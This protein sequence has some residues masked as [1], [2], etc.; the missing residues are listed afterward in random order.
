M[1]EVNL[2]KITELRHT[3]HKHAE[4]PCKEFQT[5]Q[6]LIDFL[7]KN[8][9]LDIVDKGAWFY[10]IHKEN[11]KNRTI[12][13]RAD[14]DAVLA[15][16]GKPKHMCGH[17]GHSAGLCGLALEI[18]GKEFG[19]NIILLF[20]HAEEIGYGA[21]ECSKVI[22]EC[23]IDEIYGL[24]NIPGYEKGEI[25]VRKGT[26]SCASKG[27][28]I[29]FKGTPAHAAYPEDGKNP[30]FAV[31]QLLNEIKA[32]ANPD[33]YKELVLCTVVG[34]K[35]G[36]KAFGVSASYGEI[37]LTIRGAIEEELYMLQREIEEKVIELAKAEE[38]NF[39]I[40]Y[41][42]EFPATVNH[43]E[44]VEHIIAAGKR[45]GRHIHILKEPMRWSED[46]GHYLKMVKGAFLGVGAGKN[47]P[48]LH[49]AEYEYPDEVLEDSIRI[50]VELCAQ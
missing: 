25:L 28:I 37:Y 46:F 11:V 15:P 50:F 20:Q 40:C 47:H 1:N 19:K 38:L 45:T 41:I 24:H 31:A 32:I 8:T 3:L 36:E 44:S 16:D 43:K 12:A 14:F 13:F 5:K 7:K 35:V 9:T 2:R 26:M 18:E 33:N 17:D 29:S 22:N 48:A 39:K 49:T 6:I 4:L 21:K 30:S 27:M 10:A 34:I 42:D 23:S